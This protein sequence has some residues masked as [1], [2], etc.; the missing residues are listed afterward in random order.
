M[1]CPRSPSEDPRLPSTLLYLL[2]LR[3][4]NLSVGKSSMLHR[5]SDKQWLPEDESSAKVGVDFR[6]DVKVKVK[7][8]ALLT[9]TS[10]TIT[11]SYY[12][13][14]QG[15]ILVY[16]IANREPFDVL[17]KWF[18]ELETYVSSTVMKIVVGNKVDKV[19]LPLRAKSRPLPTTHR[20]VSCVHISLTPCYSG[21][22]GF[23][24]AALH[25]DAVDT[26]VRIHGPP[27]PDTC[28]TPRALVDARG[29]AH[30]A[31][32]RDDMPGSIGLSKEPDEAEGSRCSC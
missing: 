4:G 7:V 9:I 26:H 3:I 16:D 19:C 6:M 27:A 5:L 17:P 23:T 31:G 25:V 32:A 28:R 21:M 30:A 2:L 29:R 15:I 14:V 11:S 24:P 12:R 18:S 10:P 1:D 22:R 13:G 8:R 20:Y